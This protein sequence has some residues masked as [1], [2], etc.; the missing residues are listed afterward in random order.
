MTEDETVSTFLSYHL[1]L[2]DFFNTCGI[3]NVRYLCSIF[4]ILYKRV[5]M[6]LL[7]IVFFKLNIKLGLEE[8]HFHEQYEVNDIFLG[9]NRAMFKKMLNSF[10]GLIIFLHQLFI[11]TI[12]VWQVILLFQ[13]VFPNKNYLSDTPYLYVN[14]M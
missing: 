7:P 13:K 11:Y 8:N 9:G 1:N 2:H 10:K 12:Y 14:S 6:H 4:Y 3:Q 5:T